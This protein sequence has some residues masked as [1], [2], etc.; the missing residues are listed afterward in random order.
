MQAGDLDG[1]TE[2]V[3]ALVKLD[4][5]EPQAY[6]ILGSVTEERNQVPEAIQHYEKAATLARATQQA[7]VDRPCQN[8]AGQSCCSGMNFVLPEA[9]TDETTPAP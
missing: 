4:P 8:A 6:F 7:G 3:D 5:N 2:A 1:A 9:P